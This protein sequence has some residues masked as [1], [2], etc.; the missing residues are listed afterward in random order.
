MWK[1]GEK[2]GKGKS[3]E[4][5][6]QPWPAAVEGKSGIALDYKLKM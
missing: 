6:D 2:R 3:K 5:C 1:R 4:E